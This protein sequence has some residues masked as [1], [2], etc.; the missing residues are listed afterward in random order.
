VIDGTTQE[1]QNK[2]ERNPDQTQEEV[3]DLQVE[4]QPRLDSEEDVKYI[5]TISLM[6]GGFFLFVLVSLIV[7]SCSSYRVKT[8]CLND[9]VK[10]LEQH[11]SDHDSKRLTSAEYVHVLN[12]ELSFIAVMESSN[13][14]MKIAQHT[15]CDVDWNRAKWAIQEEINFELEMLNVRDFKRRSPSNK[16][17]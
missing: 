5:G 12:D 11:K 14:I 6:V 1:K 4:S 7:T 8:D 13:E 15:Y 3:F 9:V 17:R 16:N 2:K 10:D